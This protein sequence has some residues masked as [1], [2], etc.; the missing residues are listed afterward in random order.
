MRVTLNRPERRNSQ[1]PHMWHAL[2]ALGD[3][4]PDDVRV[5]VLA[6]NGQSFSAG[7]D[8]EL[9][10]P[11]QPGATTLAGMARLPAEEFDAAVAGFQRGF[12]WWHERPVV[13]VAVVHGHAIGAGFQLALATDLM[14]VAESASL[15]M[16]EVQLGL[17]PDLAGT[18][19][20]V[21]AVGPR[22]ALEI[23][24][25]GRAVSGAEAAEMGLAV[26]CVPDDELAAATDRLVES[27]LAPMPGATTAVLELLRGAAHRDEVSQ[28]AAER[29][30]QYGRITELLALLGG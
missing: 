12:T 1:T 18:A 14:I 8:R 16:K 26:A 11:P 29:Q 13:T 17:V 24:V 28:R 3:D 30:A 20:L 7:L 21:A 19:P 27:L 22:R 5:V 25:T 9:L 4:L 23:C 2:A 10:A 6:G 15:Q